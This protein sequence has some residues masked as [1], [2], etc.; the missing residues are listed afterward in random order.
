V[1]A[2]VIAQVKSVIVTIVWS[3]VVSFVSLKVIDVLVGLRVS[4]EV[5]MAGLDLVEHGEEGYNNH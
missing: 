1:T 4:E 2:Q 5:E 3:G